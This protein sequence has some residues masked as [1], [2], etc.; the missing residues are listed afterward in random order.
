MKNQRDPFIIQSQAGAAKDSSLINFSYNNQQGDTFFSHESSSLWL[1]R[2]VSSFKVY[3][4]FFAILFLFFILFT[5]VGYLQLIKGENYYG[6]AEGNRLKTEYLPADR[7]IIF[8]RWHSPLVENVAAFSVYFHTNKF[9]GS[10]EDVNQ[11]TEIMSNL[12]LDKKSP[13]LISVEQLLESKKQTPILIKENLSYETALELMIVS[14]KF[15]CLEVVIDPYRNYL[16]SDVNAHLLGYTSRI[17][18][19]DKEEYLNNSYQL[20]ERIGRTGLEEYYESELRGEPGRQSIE[21]DSFGQQRNVINEQASIPGKNLVLSI[22]NGL[23]EEIFKILQRTL[24]TKAVAIVALD[25]NSGK[26]RALISWPSF[27]HNAFGQTLAQQDY[28]AIINN[29]LKPLFNRTIS[30]EYPSGSTIKLIVGAAA[31]DE[32]LISRYS[33]IYSSGGVWYDKWFFPDWK[34]G[35]HGS[36]DINKA[37]AESVNTFFYYLA[38][39]DFDGH[40]GLGLDKMLKYFSDVGLNQT[41]GIDIYGEQTGFLP[42]IE[43]KKEVKDEVWF[44]GD[45]LH[46][47]IGQGDILVTP[48]QVASYTSIVANR[49]TLYQP[50][51]VEEIIDPITSDVQIIE[52]KILKRR[53]FKKANLDIIADGMRSGVLMGSARNLAGNILE[54]AGKTG[55]AQ[56]SGNQEPHAWFTSFAPFKNPELVLTILIENGETSDNAVHLARDIWQWYLENRK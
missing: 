49:G 20:F 54:I 44:P 22:D 32:G 41:L 29:P 38:L 9:F 2:A 19:K 21:V 12:S 40:K 36:T 46:L 4:I 48:L 27:D 50:Q 6:I 30:G 26:V 34:A 47:V 35:G 17:S 14:K 24:S 55:T 3:V 25:P 7:G 56:V 43:W 15:N 13:L 33:Q 37:I 11:L 5:R 8:D 45:T 1:G 23:Q 28:E 52:P 51:L 18:D 39:E 10:K 53:I 31:L 16:G 42:S